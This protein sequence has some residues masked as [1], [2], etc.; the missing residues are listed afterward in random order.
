MRRKNRSRWGC[1]QTD[2]GGWRAVRV[3]LP[4]IMQ[5]NFSHNQRLMI[6][7][8]N[9]S[10]WCNIL[11][12]VRFSLCVTAKEQVM[13]KI[14]VLDVVSRWSPEFA[15]GCFSTYEGHICISAAFYLLSA[16]I[17]LVSCSLWVSCDTILMRNNLKCNGNGW[18]SGL[19]YNILGSTGW[20]PT[21]H[22]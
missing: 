4:N 17:L 22:Y 8:R 21:A 5:Q 18:P 1:C 6:E 15:K 16:L 13:D 11:R 2:T 9:G 3:L 19:P 12:G 10:I 20:K 14:T 7:I